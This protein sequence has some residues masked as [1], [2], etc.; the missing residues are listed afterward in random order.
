MLTFYL[1]PVLTPEFA[2]E[3]TLELTLNTQSKISN[4]SHDIRPI[5]RVFRAGSRHGQSGQLPRA[6]DFVGAPN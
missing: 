2:L 6:P 4:I 3:F 1:R 5:W